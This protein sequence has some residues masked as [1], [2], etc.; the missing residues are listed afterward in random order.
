MFFLASKIL[1]LFLAP[2][3]LFGSVMIVCAILLFTRFARVGRWLVAITAFLYLACGV[4][5][6][7]TLL[8]RPLE[9]RLPPPPSDM[10]APAGI[11]VLGGGIN[12]DITAARGTMTL[13]EAGTRVTA[14]ATLMRRFPQAEL[15]F[16]GGSANITGVGFAE[17]DAA[18]QL[19][20]D[21]GIAPDRMIMENRSR[22]TYENA[23]FTRDLVHPQPGSRWLL[24]TSAVHMPR[25]LSL[26]RAVGFPIVPFPA[27]YLTQGNEADFL[28]LHEA[29]SGLKLLDAGAHEWLGLIVNRVTGRTETLLPAQD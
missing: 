14:A 17:A 28:Q 18:R 3:T 23:V 26:F 24:V 29:S 12:P 13:T 19:F 6:V 2:S 11:V 9:D 20:L 16:T 21:L 15:V 1:G 5:P 27:D 25:A 7:S 10:P 8:L 4:G 22:N